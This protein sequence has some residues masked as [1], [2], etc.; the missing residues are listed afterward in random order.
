M[1][2]RRV[3]KLRGK[4]EERQREGRIRR[5]KGLTRGEKERERERERERESG[6]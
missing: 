5:D 1:R 4:E 2:R 6:R 3:N